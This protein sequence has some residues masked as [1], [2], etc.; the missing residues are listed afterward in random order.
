ME[1]MIKKLTLPLKLDFE[2]DYD[3]VIESSIDTQTYAEDYVRS[4]EQDTDKEP[5]YSGHEDESRDIED[6][7]ERT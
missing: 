6:L 2:I 5:Y 1:K 3:A 4:N 7:F